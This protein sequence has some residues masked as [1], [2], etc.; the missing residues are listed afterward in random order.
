MNKKDPF[1]NPDG[2]QSDLEIV[3]KEF[4]SVNPSSISSAFDFEKERIRFIIGCKGSGKTHYMRILQQKLKANES[5]VYVDDIK[6]VT[7]GTEEVFKFTNLYIGKNTKRINV[8]S[9]KWQEIW[10]KSIYVSI[11]TNALYNNAL[12]EYLDASDIEELENC[13]EKLF[14]F[15]PKGR[16]DIFSALLCL[17]NEFN[18]YNQ[19]NSFLKHAEWNNLKHLLQDI[20]L[21]KLPPIYYFLDSMDDA[22]DNMPQYWQLCQKGAFYAVMYFLRENVIREKIHI[23]LVIR[24]TIFMTIAQSDHVTKICNESHIFSLLWNKQSLEYFIKEKI[25]RLDDCYFLGDYINN[26]KN[27]QTWLG[28]EKIK[29]NFF[30]KELKIIDLI[31][32]MVRPAPRDI[33]VVCNA[34]ST[35]RR[36][37]EE[38]ESFDIDKGINKV[39]KEKA[40]EIGREIISNCA[41]QMRIES[42]PTTAGRDNYSD[43]YTAQIDDFA[44][45]DPYYEKLVEI[46]SNLDKYILSKDDLKMIHEHD[47]KELTGLTILDILWQN[48]AIGFFQDDEAIF[49]MQNGNSSRKFPENKKTIFILPA[50]F[51]NILERKE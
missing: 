8:E 34:L 18:T 4:I 26:G 13:K 44:T 3:S 38:D 35:I 48:R 36:K 40:L 19:M 14:R 16:Y 24:D 45:D 12:I 6:N 5:V 11:V 10:T 47:D 42:M 20:I 32:S 7:E 17:I 30:N 2:S 25:K 1:G 39:I 9:E 15:L 46:L 29:S 33:I 51:L 27:I 43:Y 28:K 41:K 22:Y 21:K 31:I 23:V 37:I 49:Y 50:V